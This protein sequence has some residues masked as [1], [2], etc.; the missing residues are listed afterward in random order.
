MAAEGVVEIYNLFDKWASNG[1]ET[2]RERLQQLLGMSE[3]VSDD[4]DLM[5]S[6][7][8]TDEDDA[9][10]STRQMMSMILHKLR[11]LQSRVTCNRAM[12]EYLECRLDNNRELPST[13]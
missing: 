3:A 13:P 9:D 7:S 10:T 4:D 5:D 8:D 1:I 12:L 2:R 6:E 11:S